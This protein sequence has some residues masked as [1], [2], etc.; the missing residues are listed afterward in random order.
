MV[1]QTETE[2]THPPTIG[3]IAGEIEKLSGE[4]I[5]FKIIR[6]GVGDINESDMQL[7]AT[8]AETIII[9]F[10]VK[11]DKK[12]ANINEY[13]TA[14]IKTFNIIYKINYFI[15]KVYDSCSKV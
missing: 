8:D 10:N 1:L 15:Y 6:S 9:G 14:V 3:A 11:E 5:F 4:G 7:A 12:I 2:T 13:E